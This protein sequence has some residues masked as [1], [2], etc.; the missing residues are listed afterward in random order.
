MTHLLAKSGFIMLFCALF[1]LFIRPELSFFLAFA[2]VF[3]LVGFAAIEKRFGDICIIFTAAALGFFLSGLHTVNYILP[4]RALNGLRADITGT[5]TEVSSGSGNPVYT[6]KTGYIGIDG[7]PQNISVL[8]SGW[9]ESSAN[10]YDIISCSAVFHIYENGGLSEILADKAGKIS[11]RAYTDSPIEVIGKDRSSFGYHISLIR[12]KIS[13]VIYRF[14]LGG[15]APF[16]EQILIGTR[17]ELDPD[18]VL[19]FRKSGMS[20]ILAISG[21]HMVIIIGLLE[22]LIGFYKSGRR[23]GKIKAAVLIAAVVCYMFIG[24]LGM[25]VLRSGFMLIA[26]YL[27]RIFLSGSKSLDNLGIAVAAVLTADPSAA[28]DI[29]FLMSVFSCCAIG[30]FSQPLKKKLLVILKIRGGSPADF[31]AESVCVSIIAFLAVLPVSALVFGEVSL[32]APFSNIFSGFLTQCSIIS[33]L[34]TVLLGFVPTFGFVAEFTALISGIFIEWLFGIA[35]FFSSLPFSAVDFSDGWMLLWLFGSAV[36]IIFPALKSGGFRTVALSS[37]MSVLVLLFG[38]LFDFVFFSGVS[39]IR[40]T[41]LESGTAISCSKDGESV[42]IVNG[43]SVSD[44]YRLDFP[45]GG[46][47]TVISTGAK[48]PS[49]EYSLLSFSDPEYAFMST[50]DSLE[51]CENSRLISKGTI[52]LSESDFITVIP[53]SAICFET[54]GVTLL[55]I[56]SECD[57]MDIEPKFRRAD[58]IILENISPAEYSALRSGYLV[59]RSF[60]GYYSK[61]EEIIVLKNG[62]TGFFAFEGNLM[63]GRDAR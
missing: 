30:V 19:S 24:G 43:I 61:T 7:A 60:G 56:F 28:C 50:E 45:A 40:I 8:I 12:E 3:A 18:T 63:K 6:V 31:A 26:H 39:E 9:D 42:L 33:G 62:K 52:S 48:N 20:H 29:G 10:E 13:S 14:Y 2:A 16:M 5:V 38:I 47:G 55:Y 34:I 59:L 23:A 49:A 25:S 32:L 57:I 51:H 35:D 53:E 37:A 44:R 58:I 21:M 41:A 54:N 1:A 36:L 4:A 22:R 17:G 46:Y 15:H 27:A 11:V